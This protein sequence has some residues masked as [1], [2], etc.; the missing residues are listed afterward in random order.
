MPQ[1]P[2]WEDP[3]HT[4]LPREPCICNKIPKRHPMPRAGREA[5]FLVTSSLSASG[6]GGKRAVGSTTLGHLPILT[7]MHRI[8]RTTPQMDR[9]ERR[10]SQCFHTFPIPFPGKYGRIRALI[11]QFSSQGWGRAPSASLGA[12][13]G[14]AFVPYLKMDAVQQDND[15]TGT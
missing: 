14:P 5:A 6:E 8:L 12:Q 9:G 3:P 7:M 15:N 1:P 13:I 4:L 2:C 11:L 10:E